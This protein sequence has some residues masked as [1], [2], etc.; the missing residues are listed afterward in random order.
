MCRVFS[1]RLP[2]SISS[3]GMTVKTENREKMIALIR[4]TAISGPR[5]NFMNIMATRPPTVVR[6][7]APT[8]GMAFDRETMTASRSS[9]LVRSSLKRLQ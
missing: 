2:I 1:I 8:S 5:R 4:L 7:L 3:P 6:L 9:C